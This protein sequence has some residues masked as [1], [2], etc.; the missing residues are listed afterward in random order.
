MAPTPTST[1]SLLH[2]HPPMTHWHL[3]CLSPF[4]FDIY[5]YI[6]DLEMWL[7]IFLPII[8][9]SIHIIHLSCKNKSLIQHMFQLYKTINNYNELR[10]VSGPNT[11]LTPSL[12]NRTDPFLTHL[13]HF[14][15][16]IL[17]SATCSNIH[18]VLWRRQGQRGQISNQVWVIIRGWLAC[19][20]PLDPH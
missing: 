8:L 7:L 16:Q 2:P 4:S 14:W 17:F 15:N 20:N 9:K 1:S 11:A 3:L 6:F 10:N 5:I 19:I 13:S 12:P 18:T